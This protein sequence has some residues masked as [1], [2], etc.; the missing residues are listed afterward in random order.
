MSFD[1]TTPRVTTFG[2]DGMRPKPIA[3]SKQYNPPPVIPDLPLSALHSHTKGY[4]FP[5]GR[6]WVEGGANTAREIGPGAYN[7]FNEVAVTQGSRPAH[8][9]AKTGATTMRVEH[10]H[11]VYCSPREMKTP[12]VGQ[13]DVTDST[14][15]TKGVVIPKASRVIHEAVN[16]SHSLS[17]DLTRFSS[18]PPQYSMRVPQSTREQ[19]VI[20]THGFL[21][22]RP[23]TIL[24][25]SPGV[26]KYD[27][28]KGGDY[29]TRG[30][31]IPK[32]ARGD[33]RNAQKTATY[34]ITK[35]D[36][37]SSRIATSRRGKFADGKRAQ[38]MRLENGHMFF[39]TSRAAAVPGVENRN[40]IFGPRGGL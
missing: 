36:T 33:D 26:G 39:C 28:S 16:P 24:D 21:T 9:M 27:L 32:S 12:G 22:Y 31:T 1:P 11:A 19:E 4:K 38:T 6:R 13:Y 3:L 30:V 29:M 35:Y 20:V 34:D 40:D 17:Y 10:G 37:I 2:T 14:F 23:K 8:T 7:T 18:R 25:A 5:T 15:L